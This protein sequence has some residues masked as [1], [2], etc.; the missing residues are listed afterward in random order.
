MLAM[1]FPS[2]LSSIWLI[3]KKWMTS[4]LL[5]PLSWLIFCLEPTGTLSSLNIE[6][7]HQPFHTFFPLTDQVLQQQECKLLYPRK[8]GQKPENKSKNRYKNILPCKSCSNLPFPVSLSSCG[9]NDTNRQQTTQR[10]Q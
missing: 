3:R 2:L 4:E 6:F 9:K 5:Y 1:T 7:Y 10:P 8:E